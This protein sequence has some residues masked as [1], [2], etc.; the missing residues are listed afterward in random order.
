MSYLGTYLVKSLHHKRLS[1]STSAVA[2]LATGISV[3]VGL[4]AAH[5]APKG[6][7][8]V[9]VALHLAKTPL[10]VKL[11]PVLTGVAVAVAT[12]A[13]L[14]KFYS[15]CKEREDEGIL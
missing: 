14:I 7:F 2:G 11:A 3:V 6:V 13:G 12:A 8:K 4:I 10:I 15:W 1:N 9:R 5:F